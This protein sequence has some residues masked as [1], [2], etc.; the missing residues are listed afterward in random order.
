MG[1]SKYKVL[2][3]GPAED[4]GTKHVTCTLGKDSP[5]KAYE[6]V[7]VQQLQRLLGAN[8]EKLRKPLNFMCF[9]V[10]DVFLH[11]DAPVILTFVMLVISCV[12][13]PTATTVTCTA[14]FVALYALCTVMHMF[15][16]W[17]SVTEKRH[18]VVAVMQTVIERWQRRLAN[19]SKNASNDRRTIFQF[20]SPSLPAN[21]FRIVGIVDAVTGKVKHLLKCLVMKGA[22]RLHRATMKACRHMEPAGM[23]KLVDMMRIVLEGDAIILRPLQDMAPPPRHPNVH[24]TSNMNICGGDGK[25]AEED[26]STDESDDEYDPRTEGRNVHALS[27]PQQMAFLV[28]RI[29]FLAWALGMIACVSTG[30]MVHF[31]AG[32][33][34]S[35]GVFLNPAVALLGLLPVNAKLLNSVLVLYANTNL[36]CLFRQL[37]AKS[38]H[39]VNDR[40]PLIT[41][42]TTVQALFRVL[43]RGSEPVHLCFSS[44][45]VETLGTTTVVAL[46][47][48]A[49]VVTDMVPIPARLLM[50]KRYEARESSSSSDNDDDEYDGG[51]KQEQCSEVDPLQHMAFR[52][53]EHFLALKRQ[54]RQKR[55]QKRRFLELQMTTSPHEDLAVQFADSRELKTWE[56]N[57]NSLSLCLL[58]HAMAP[59]PSVY[60]TW[61]ESFRF[62]DQGMRWAR[63]VHW[64]SRASGLDDSLA[65]AF[66][67]VA[68]IFRTNTEKWR[69]KCK[70]CPEQACTLLAIGSGDIIHAFTLG[71]V[72]MVAH[73][74]PF[75]FDGYDVED[76]DEEV[77]EEVVNVGT[78]VWED[79]IGLE[80]VAASHALIPEEFLSCVEK[81]PRV[82]G[83][84]AE[85]FFHNGVQ[86]TA[87][88]F[89]TVLNLHL[90]R[91]EFGNGYG[92]MTDSGRSS[93]SLQG[94]A[95]SGK[96]C[97]RN[98]G[99]NRKDVSANLEER[100]S[101][102][103]G[104]NTYAD[105]HV[106]TGEGVLS[107]TVSDC[108]AEELLKIV[109][110]PSHTFL[111]LVGLQDSI[112]PNVQ[113]A[114]AV[115]DEA[116]IRCMYFCSE[117]ER[118][119]KSLGNRLGLE[120]D[121]NCCISLDEE[122]MDLD[123]HSIRAQ[124]PVGI[125]SIR[126]HI[127]HVDPIPLQVNMFSH[128]HGAST[129]AMLSI[130][131]DNHEVV[132][133]VGSTFND[134]N[135][136]SYIQADLSIGVLPQRRGDV[137][138]KEEHYLEK[139]ARV[140]HPSVISSGDSGT[141][142]QFLCRDVVDLIGC[143]CT[144]SDTRTSSMLPIVT[145]LIRQ[146]R[147]RLSGIGNCIAFT[148]HANFLVTFLN[149]ASVIVGGPLLMDSATVV[150]ELNVIVP[151]LALSCTY[152]ACADKDP[153]KS[154][155]SRHNYF[156]RL[157]ILRHGVVVWCLRYIPSLIA[158]L[159][160]GITCGFQ[161]CKKSSL[162]DL[163]LLSSDECMAMTRGYIGVTLNYW[164]MIHSWTHMSRHDP[165]TLALSFKPRYGGPYMY[166]FRSARWV[167]TNALTI[168]LSVLFAGVGTLHGG[169]LGPVLYPSR[170]HFL[171]SLFF[172][173]LLL[174]LDVPIKTWRL[175]RA[176]LMQK[177]RRLS[178]GTRLGM[179]SPRGDYEPEVTSF[180]EGVG[181]SGVAGSE[182]G[183][184]AATNAQQ[185]NA[186]EK[187]T[188]RRRIR[189]IL[190]RFTTIQ[191][192]KLELNCVCCDHVGGN[193][194]TYHVNS[195]DM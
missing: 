124:L 26:Q 149:L 181:N 49:G 33:L 139:H 84:F 193:Y 34:V 126:R 152:T 190:Y 12:L 122:A 159:A 189:E 195:T 176:T 85:F 3:N 160:L 164:L 184:E 137:A 151:I 47:D 1:R 96:T 185:S 95:H 27:V 187:L 162:H 120:T 11:Q 107:R 161:L 68:R 61:Q 10:I 129:R 94:S 167:V 173:V 5:S 103:S 14:L 31:L 125:K 39:A 157:K 87:E 90:G 145:T 105:G 143:A 80:T 170:A 9:A 155:Q 50:L 86:V 28:Y 18:C 123:A 138:E 144:L 65:N 55:S 171:I 38:T 110:G 20:F 130:L 108:F 91:R 89:S 79:G 77:R 41:F 99:N 35:D 114:M 60:E 169:D 29:L 140:S 76:L 19:E 64:V 36:N 150:F 13:H 98:S 119:T 109:V 127:V 132:A 112:R 15:L 148:M 48:T 92:E 102:G 23:F 78:M 154:I 141:S 182:C 194:A 178:F 56:T 81:L 166:L 104:C 175:R 188:L 146:A 69:G 186:N 21:A 73:S 63:S 52:D 17:L 133:A 183:S 22:Y 57:V 8:K 53:R 54:V 101:D 45:L 59:E 37:V 44:S 74:C 118:R 40:I 7:I 6:E 66:R 67:I 191:G 192:G 163:M 136:R 30:C 82:D 153:M 43:W 51:V 147:Q 128:A 172:P 100:G 106:R 62:C 177:F 24:S 180:T 83:S 158:L 134:S 2:E 115:L 70:E 72:S 58:I 116:G 97:S 16:L 156:V 93:S 75:H 25:G 71:T 46:L 4:Y 168:L 165:L 113:N 131:Q 111:G 117:G 174:V 135:V 88:N 32:T 42:N 121:W 142:D 179:H